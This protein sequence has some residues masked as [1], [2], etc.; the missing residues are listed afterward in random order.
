MAAF[1]TGSTIGTDDGTMSHHGTTSTHP[2]FPASRKVYVEGTT[3]DI[4]VPMREI[5]LSPTKS[6][7][8]SPVVAEPPPL[9]VY[10]TSGPYT[11]SD[12][13]TDARRGLPPLRLPW[14]LA[15]GDHDH[16]EPSY[17][18]NA[19]HPELTEDRAFHRYFLTLVAAAVLPGLGHGAPGPSFVVTSAPY[20]SPQGNRETMESNQ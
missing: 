18:A 10:N 4:R 17:R 7:P 20:Q 13:L 1:Q 8:R 14:I 19:F 3:A 12:A 6:H 11:N 5:A 15:R 16:A 9:H 2:S